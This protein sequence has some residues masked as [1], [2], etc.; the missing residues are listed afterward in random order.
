[1]QEEKD[2]AVTLSTMSSQ[3]S[4]VS[5]KLC[6]ERCGNLGRWEDSQLADLKGAMNGEKDNAAGDNAISEQR[7]SRFHYRSGIIHVSLS[8]MPSVYRSKRQ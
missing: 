7:R 3:A 6:R 4:L 8:C 2:D 5:E 1:M